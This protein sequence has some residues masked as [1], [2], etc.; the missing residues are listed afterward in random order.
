MLSISD[1]RK[2]LQK[3]AEIVWLVKLYLNSIKTQ[4]PLKTKVQHKT[5]Q[6]TFQLAVIFLFKP[7]QF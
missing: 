3:P 2:E 6:L 4:L 5:L 7:T 1:F